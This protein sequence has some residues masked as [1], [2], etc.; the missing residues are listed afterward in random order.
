MAKL[1][2]SGKSIS[3]VE[4]LNISPHGLWLL[5]GD[6]EYFLGA[7]DYPWFNKAKVADICNVTLIGSNHLHWAAL[8]VD[9]E[10]SALENPEDYPLVYN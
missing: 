10:V 5:V 2:K 8:D 7:N 3:A 1:Q 9:L 4:V 6:R